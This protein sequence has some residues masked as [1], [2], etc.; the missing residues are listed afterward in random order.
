[1]LERAP[2]L[3]AQ[4]R[5]VRGVVGGEDVGEAGRYPVP[6]RRDLRDRGPDLGGR[7]VLH[8]LAQPPRPH[9]RPGPRPPPR[10]PPH[11][12][13]PGRP[14]TR[15][16]TFPATVLPAPRTRTRRPTGA[17][18]PGPASSA[19]TVAAVPTTLMRSPP[20]LSPAAPTQLATLSLTMGWSS[21]D[22]MS[23]TPVT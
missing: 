14:G 17:A 8:G 15:A 11:P 4:S 2:L 21:T 5:P 16:A 10:S 20:V 12:T 18:R 6:A 13:R 22:A 7:L 3:F 1:Q 23:M 9:P 19:A